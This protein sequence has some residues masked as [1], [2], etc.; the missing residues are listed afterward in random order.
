MSRH[1]P[2]AKTATQ[3]TQASPPPPPPRPT[4]SLC[5]EN[6]T[7]KNNIN[8]HL[9]HNLNLMISFQFLIKMERF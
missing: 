7:V 5:C 6:L 2:A 1:I 8:I 4:C 9:I 3:A